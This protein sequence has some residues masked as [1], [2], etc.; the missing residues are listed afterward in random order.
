MPRMY[1]GFMVAIILGM[2]LIGEV[3][4]GQ[5]TQGIGFS[6]DV[7]LELSYTAVPPLS[8]NIETDLTLSISVTDFTFESAT[9]F[10]LS[11]FQAQGFGASVDLGAVRIADEVLFDPYFSWNRLSVDA[12]IVGVTVGLDLILADIGT[13][14]PSYS[15]GAVLELS[16]GVISGFSI[17]TLTG[18]GA[19][20]LVNVLDGVEAPYSYEL[21]EL[22]YHLDNLCLSPIDLENLFYL[23]P[24]I[25]SGF[26]FE[27]ELVRL[28]AD[29][30]GIISSS[31]TWLDWNGFAKEVFE[32]GYRFE[33]PSLAFLT[34]I[35]ID[36][37]FAISGL[38][39]ILN[40]EICEV[41]FTSW[42]SFAAPTSPSVLPIVF[43][44][45][46]FAV[47]FELFGVDI[48]SETD[49]DGTFLF[50]RQ[51]LAIEAEI[52]PV[53]FTSL[54]VFDGS[55]FSSQCLQAGVTFCGV[56]LYTTAAFDTSGITEVSV[57][58][59]FTF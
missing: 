35:T 58:F 9:V 4:L 33:E 29:F 44:G 59:E 1:A 11:G 20:D 7:G 46:G 19:T 21:L 10:D 2:L 41:Q 22:F 13:Q 56:T 16:S 6:G 43:S 12:E 24:T 30:C 26:Y 50:E 47:S 45:Q 15:M 3:M 32:F 53:T 25:V 8:Y 51:L 18:F 42:T 14:S 39:F 37:S 38:D 54:T 40:L 48:T 34:A 36:E 23:A 55:G 28:E 52:D 5:E 31:S 27:E 17:T 57:G 49:F